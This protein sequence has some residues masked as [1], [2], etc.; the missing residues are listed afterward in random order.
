VKVRLRAAFGA[1]S[2]ASWHRYITHTDKAARIRHS[3]AFIAPDRAIAEMRSLAELADPRAKPVWHLVTSFDPDEAI[4]LDGYLAT[5]DALYERLGAKDLLSIDAAHGDARCRHGHSLLVRIDPR[6]GVL[7]IPGRVG[8]LL[9]DFEREFTLAP[10][11]DRRVNPGWHPGRL[12]DAEAHTGKMSLARFLRDELAHVEDWIEHDH[13]IAR[14]QIDLVPA[15][16]GYVYRDSPGARAIAVRQ[17]IVLDRDTR[18]LLGPRPPGLQIEPPLTLQRSYSDYRVHELPAPGIAPDIV[19]RWE[20]ARRS[21]ERVPR[22][23]D[24]ARIVRHDE[25]AREP[26][27]RAVADCRV[28][29]DSVLPVAINAIGP[30]GPRMNPA[31]K[32]APSTAP[33]AAR[34]DAELA[35]LYAEMRAAV[36]QTTPLPAAEYP[37]DENSLIANFDVQE[38]HG[39]VVHYELGAAAAAYPLSDDVRMVARNFREAYR[40]QNAER[41]ALGLAPQHPDLAPTLEPSGYYDGGPMYSGGVYEAWKAGDRDRAISIALLDGDLSDI[42]QEVRRT[43]AA[44]GVYLPKE[45]E[46]LDNAVVRAVHVGAAA[47]AEFPQAERAAAEQAA[48]LSR[49]KEEL[50]ALGIPLAPSRELEAAQRSSETVLPPPRTFDVNA[51]SE[52]ASTNAIGGPGGTAPPQRDPLRERFEAEYAAYLEAQALSEHPITTILGRHLDAQ[53]NASTAFAA[54]RD[55][56][57]LDAL[58]AR[59]RELELLKLLATRQEETTLSLAL[60]DARGLATTMSQTD[61]LDSTHA[62][63]ATE[64]EQLRTEL[65]KTAEAQRQPILFAYDRSLRPLLDT[66]IVERDGTLVYLDSTGRE[67]FTEREGT[68]QLA[69]RPKEESIDVALRAAAARWGEIDIRGDEQFVN[70]AL[71]RAVALGIGVA[72]PELQERVAELQQEFARTRDAFRQ[73]RQTHEL[74][75]YGVLLPDWADRASAMLAGAREETLGNAQES[76]AEKIAQIESTMLTTLVGQSAF[77]RQESRLVTRREPRANG[78][79]FEAEYQG[80]VH[81]PAGRIAIVRHPVLDPANDNFQPKG[82]VKDTF[83]FS[84]V[85]IEPD[86]MIK[87]GSTVVFVDGQQPEIAIE[88]TLEQRDRKRERESALAL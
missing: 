6:S 15:G 78:A 70:R 41:A 29:E 42:M 68:Y 9:A 4:T 26:S 14:R 5:M 47:G 3:P 13:R 88:R 19:E 71:E 32:P 12:G 8:H 52:P 82:A 76:K 18:S 48:A 35:R 22:L 20:R 31:P 39:R 1:T 53:R 33:I 40:R 56:H 81:T 80:A 49:F 2:I 61:F 84:L 10:L 54:L 34:H 59:S 24:F 75:A 43:A 44:F 72:T 62:F 16:S 67:H 66:T 57:K 50:K 30:G 46:D 17:S 37:F 63:S 86:R 83:L 77:A 85:P 45:S 65:E 38:Q 87:P 60:L 79:E 73:S 55:E 28:L 74:A 27:R 7:V 36:A 51:I 11:R 69:R 21:G 23:G 25:T 64:R 58:T